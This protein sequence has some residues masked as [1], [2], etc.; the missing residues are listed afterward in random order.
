[1]RGDKLICQRC[2]HTWKQRG[3]QLPEVCPN[4]KSRLWNIPKVTGKGYKKGRYAR[5]SPNLMKSLEMHPE[6]GK[7]AKPNKVTVVFKCETGFETMTFTAT[8]EQIKKVLDIF[9]EDSENG[10]YD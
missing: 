7:G 4:C 6:R 10:K 3:D 2:W 5:M 1:M 8:K 9:L